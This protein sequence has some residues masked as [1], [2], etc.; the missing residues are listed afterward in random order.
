[1]FRSLFASP[2]LYPKIER[3]RRIAPLHRSTI[4]QWVSG[5]EGG[6]HPQPL[7]LY[8][9][10]DPLA[11]ESLVTLKVPLQRMGDDLNCRLEMLEAELPRTD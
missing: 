4:N 5:A 9:L 6:L 10:T 3:R 8:I 1:L 2:C 7:T 11:A